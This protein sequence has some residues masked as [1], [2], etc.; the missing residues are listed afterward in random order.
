MIVAVLL[1]GAF[2]GISSLFEFLYGRRM[3]G[4]FLSRHYR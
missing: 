3:R 4:H 1:L 2:A